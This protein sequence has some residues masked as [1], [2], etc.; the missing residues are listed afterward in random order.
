MNSVKQIHLKASQKQITNKTK[1][2]VKRMEK[3][4]LEYNRIHVMRREFTLI[5]LLIVIAI[6]AILAGMLLPALNQAKL[7]AQSISCVNNLKQCITAHQMYAMDYHD[8]MYVYSGNYSWAKILS[9]DGPQTTN[10]GET[11][12]LGYLN[13]KST[14]C[15]QIK[16]T[17]TSTE[18]YGISG[19]S[20]PGYLPHGFE[21]DSNIVVGVS[22]GVSYMLQT[23]RLKNPSACI[24]ATDSFNASTGL[25]TAYIRHALSTQGNTH[26]RHSSQANGC[27]MDGHAAP[28]SVKDALYYLGRGFSAASG[29]VYFY[30]QKS[31]ILQLT[32][33]PIDI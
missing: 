27:F 7:K 1:R 11:Y 6:I 5:E 31:Q 29:Y 24:L 19:K 30:T 8:W 12:N 16:Y 3:A 26:F 21:D 17:G 33:L 23:K 14:L 13:R 22:G 15:P 10:H 2:K 20:A 25:Q 28:Y 32:L 4:P 9:T 18:A